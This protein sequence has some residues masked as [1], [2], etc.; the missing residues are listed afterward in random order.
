MTEQYEEIND[1]RMSVKEIANLFQNKKVKER[2]ITKGTKHTGR[3][4]TTECNVIDTLIEQTKAPVPMEM[5]KDT[6]QVGKTGNTT[7]I[8]E[9]VR[10]HNLKLPENIIVTKTAL[11]NELMG[12]TE[13][14]K[15]KVRVG[16]KETRRSKEHK[17][18]FF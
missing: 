18:Y 16:I 7:K 12:K 3:K 6:V 2:K 9:S 10:D 1:E 13:E 5:S 14:Y 15:G 11:F 4:Q 17:F 8:E